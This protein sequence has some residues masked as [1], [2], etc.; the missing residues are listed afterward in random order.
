MKAV[1]TLLAIVFSSTSFA[2]M[3]PNVVEDV[4][5]LANPDPRWQYFGRFGVA[6]DGDFAVVSGERFVPDGSGGNRH[7]GAI[8]L[9]QRSGS[10]W[11]HTGRLGPVGV[12]T[13]LK[14]GLAMKN[15][16]L[17]T[18]M[19]RWRI[20]QRS[21][22]D[23]VLQPVAGIAPTALEGP[24]IE[25]DRGRI[26]APAKGCNWSAVVLRR[27]GST[28]R[29]ES[30]LIGHDKGCERDVPDTMLDIEDNE[31]LIYNYAN[32][33]DPAQV[34]YYRRDSAGWVEAPPHGGRFGGP[35]SSGILGPDVAISGFLRAVTGPREHGTY[36]N[37]LDERS[38]DFYFHGVGALGLQPT[39]AFLEPSQRS[40]TAIERAE[41]L[42]AQRNYS[43]DR[44]AYVYNLFLGQ[45]NEPY[46]G[47][48]VITLQ[49][50]TGASLGDKSDTSGTRVIVSGRTA[51]G[52]EDVVRI[53]ELPTSYENAMTQ[54]EDF[55]RTTD[56][57]RWQTS[58]GQYSAHQF[59]TDGQLLQESF[60]PGRTAA[61]LPTSTWRNQ[62]IQAQVKV[63]SLQPW[64][65]AGLVTRRKDDANF[66]AAVIHG[67]GGV[68]LLRVV[69]GVETTLGLAPSCDGPF[70]RYRFESIESTHRVFCDDAL[71]MVRRDSALQGGTVGVATRESG[72]LW[73]NVIATNGPRTTLY[74]QDFSTSDPGPWLGDQ[75]VWQST[76]G[77]FRQTSPT[78]YARRFIGGLTEDQIIKV[79]IKPLSFSAPTNWVGVMARYCDDRNYLYLQIDGRG[80]VSLWRRQ[81]GAITQLDTT[82]Y[83]AGGA[84]TP[85][86]V[87]IEIVAQQTRVYFGGETVA[88]LE[89]DAPP[90]PW[91]PTLEQ[92]TG[93]VGLITQNATAEFDD[94]MAYQP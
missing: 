5:T 4:A 75:G 93:R 27:Y 92:T 39:D 85:I 50:R 56:I 74:S 37:V 7:E 3:R 76:G 64:A 36:M 49:S 29:P 62:A 25:I 82:R 45:S 60:A 34:R 55:Q 32:G 2:A 52:G 28:W 23:Y 41:W 31:A 26:L 9:Y 77:V 18:I 54:Y 69:D 44:Q 58:G 80:V 1:F 10:G 63:R 88:R 68:E 46:V 73:D 70:P 13:T 19:D 48:N 14:P 22:S 83:G 94:F 15:G 89:T 43:F 35:G 30:N 86:D 91:S 17:I 24:D 57:E 61:W 65:W 20:Y 21:G 78:G 47:H 40:G 81:N 87:R 90:G 79:R 72:A 6:I 84:G 66:Y 71:V 59:G 8:F 11:T 12:I 51:T 67:T 33:S 16:V 42:I 38:S 53:F